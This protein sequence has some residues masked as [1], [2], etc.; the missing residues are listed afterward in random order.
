MRSHILIL[1]YDYC[2]SKQNYNSRKNARIW[3][4]CFFLFKKKCAYGRK[5]EK[6]I[7]TSNPIYSHESSQIF[8]SRVQLL[9]LELESFFFPF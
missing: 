3:R 5:K 4:C 7:V 6:E 8:F 9:K 2:T 1:V